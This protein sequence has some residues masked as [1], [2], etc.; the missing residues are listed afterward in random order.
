MPLIL[1]VSPKCSLVP[2]QV[3]QGCALLPSKC[4]LTEAEVS[5]LSVTKATRAALQCLRGSLAWR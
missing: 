3:P 4:Y 2:A 1:Y 5:T